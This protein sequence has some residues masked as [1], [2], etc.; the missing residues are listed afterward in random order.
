M[1]KEFITASGVEVKVGQNLLTAESVIKRAT[2]HFGCEVKV[3]PGMF[4]MAPVCA[5]WKILKKEDSSILG[6]LAL[7]TDWF[8]E[9]S[10]F[11]YG[12]NMFV[13]FCSEWARIFNYYIRYTDGV[14]EI[15][16]R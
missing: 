4:G 16:K 10:D 11:D 5:G 12:I 3:I 13:P 1:K 6:Y 15:E 9:P 7:T 14:L 8:M 2:E